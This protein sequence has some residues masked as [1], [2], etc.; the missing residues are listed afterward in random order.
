MD[1]QNP[2]QRLKNQV[3]SVAIDQNPKIIDI[4]KANFQH[5]W[6]RAA[7]IV[8]PMAAVGG[9]VGDV[10]SPIAPFVS[11][12]AALTFTLCCI[13]G[14]VWF[15]FKRREIRRALADGEIDLVEAAHIGSVNA[16]SVAFAFNLVASLVL[17]IFF[18]A[19]KVFA[20][21]SPD[22]GAIASAVPQVSELQEQILGLKRSTERIEANTEAMR[23]SLESIDRKVAHLAQAVT[24]ASVDHNLDNSNS[25]CAEAPNPQSEFSPYGKVY[26]SAD[27][28]A[29]MAIFRGQNDLGA[30]DVLLKLT[31]QPAL[32]A[33]VDG[34]VIRY[35][36]KPYSGGG[37]DYVYAEGAKE[38]VR[39]I[40]RPDDSGGLVRV[41]LKDDQAFDLKLNAN[42]SKRFC[43][44]VLGRELK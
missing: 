40:L 44:D 31:G 19:Q 10:L 25:A 37:V 23:T 11:V 18:G 35:R 20:Q 1:Q 41:F 27:V 14:I 43:P 33:G 16:W 32:E 5:L 42:K 8:V 4:A 30:N 28:T 38:P 3:G 22:R 6:S 26:E 29:E 17:M 36:A 39:M 24:T 15:G 21:S 12:L 7:K 2:E 13:S 9:F 34:Q